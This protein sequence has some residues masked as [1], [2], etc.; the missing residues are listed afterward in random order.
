MDLVIDI[1]NTNI[2]YGI[3]D[4]NRW[5]HQWR[6]ETDIQQ[7]ELYYGMHLRSL[8]LEYGI[9][10]NAIQ[11]IGLSSVVPPLTEVISGMVAKLLGSDVVV[12]G[13]EVYKCIPLHIENIY[14]IGSDLVA[15]AVAAFTK[16]QQHCLVVDFGTALTF[17]TVSDEPAILGVAIA[18]GL[19]TAMRALSTSTA[20]LPDV[21][22]ELP[23]SVLGRNTEHA[24]QAGVLIGFTGLVEK[25]IER[26]RQE[27]P[28]ACKVVAT[29]GLSSVLTPLHQQFDLIDPH[30]TLEGIRYLLLQYNAR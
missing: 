11:Y 20:K 12:M 24:L 1:G 9:K 17:T 3:Y 7:D 22:L 25:M 21:E 2:V 30:L 8:F 19:K 26:T 14:E 29:G 4:Q 10:L 15:N 16:F 18:P 23:S 27:L 28:V 13:P 5:V 6:V